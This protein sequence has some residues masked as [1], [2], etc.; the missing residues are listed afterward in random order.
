MTVTQSTL[1]L[2]GRL[3]NQMFQ[4]A[5][6]LSLAKKHNVKPFLP[7]IPMAN[8]NY[9]GN[10]TLRMFDGVLDAATWLEEV[11]AYTH[12]YGRSIKNF[13]REGHIFSYQ[14]N[15]ESLPANIDLNGYFQ[16]EKYFLN[17]REE[18]Q[19]IFS[20]ECERTN[21]FLRE[22]EK[23]KTAKKPTC[24]IHIRRTDYVNLSDFHANLCSTNYYQ[25]A[26]EIFGDELNYFVFSDDTEFS[27]IYLGSF[28]P[29]ENVTFISNDVPAPEAIYLQTF[30]D[31][32]IIANSSFSWWGAWLGKTKKKV[33]A[34][35]FWFGPKGPKD[36]Q[37]IYANNWV[38]L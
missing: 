11:G 25:T 10:E 8:N 30:T 15:F 38:T 21:A 17:V 31:Y 1:G 3:G 5:A 2:N 16:S 20:F 27:K 23:I 13:F 28:M 7:I 6:T 35:K 19:E 18:L 33:I 22:L 24:S 37:D 14:K 9:A 36:T 29:L 12:E 26:I 34:P 4:F 32:S